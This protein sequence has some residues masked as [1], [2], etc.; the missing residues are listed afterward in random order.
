MAPPHPSSASG[1]H[2][3]RRRMVKVL[4]T[5][6]LA[7]ALAGLALA[8]AA[9]NAGIFFPEKGGSPN[10]DKI[11]TLYLLIFILAWVVFLGVAGAPVLAMFKFRARP[12]LGAGQNPRNTRPGIGWGGGAVVVP[13][14][15][16]V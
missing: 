11:W 13:L 15:F 10:A 6:G 1:L 14:F 12:G 5:R 8:P 3:L 9:A 7:A 16:T 4:L 2:I